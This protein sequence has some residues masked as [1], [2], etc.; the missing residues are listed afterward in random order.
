[1]TKRSEQRIKARLERY[2]LELFLRK[3]EEGR[4][5]ERWTTGWARIKVE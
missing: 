4:K 3:E 2:L 1:M 5:G